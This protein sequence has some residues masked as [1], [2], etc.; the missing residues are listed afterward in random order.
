RKTSYYLDIKLRKRN[1]NNLEQQCRNNHDGQHR[2]CRRVFEKRLR[3]QQQSRVSPA[4]VDHLPG[5]YCYNPS[6]E[7]TYLHV[8]C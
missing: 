4:K 7:P 5:E 2:A 6:A 8:A 1:S 3:I